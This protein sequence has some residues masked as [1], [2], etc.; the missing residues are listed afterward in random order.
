[1][2]SI[3]VVEFPFDKTQFPSSLYGSK[4]YRVGNIGLTMPRNIKHEAEQL[5]QEFL[6]VCQF[7]K[8]E[9]YL[10][11]DFFVD[12]NLE[13]V[14][15]LE[16]NS[17][18]VDGWGAAFSLAKAGGQNIEEVAADARRADF[19]HYW[20]LPFSNRVYRNDF[21]FALRELNQLGVDA[22]ELPTLNG[23]TDEWIYYYGWDRPET[24]DA[25][26]APQ[27]GYE[28]ENKI[29]LARFSR[30]WRGERVKVPLGYSLGTAAWEEIPRDQVVFKF[31]EKHSEDSDRARTSILYPDEVGKGRFARQCYGRGTIVAQDLVP[32]LESDGRICQLILL[33]S[34]AAVIGGYVLWASHGTRIIT[35]A[36]EHAPLVWV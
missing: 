16:I 17:R 1:M 23:K 31:C 28:I 35:D 11:L 34:S 12:P 15:L 22:S 33:A 36:Y 10:R 14:H 24:N 6:S 25:L 27:F 3:Q 19:P 9:V 8:E 13:E 18:L 4:P 21:D 20:H 30:V 5:V 29:H 7:K 26:I 2:S 32:T